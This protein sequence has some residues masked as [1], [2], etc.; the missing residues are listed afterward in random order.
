[1]NMKRGLTFCVVGMGMFL[2]ACG[3]GGGGGSESSNVTDVFFDDSVIGV[4][5]GTVAHV[6]FSFDSDHVFHDNKNVRVVVHLPPQ[7]QLRANTGEVQ[8][9]PT[10]ESI[11]AQVF[12]C[13][14]QA[15]T[16]LLFDLDGNDL[17]TAVNPGGDADA[18]L[19]F[20]VDGVS[21]VSGAIVSA[22]ASNEQPPFACGQQFL[23]DKDAAITVS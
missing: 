13:G 1:M 11:G 21:P 2:S 17:D 10:D 14:A 18:E 19:T 5:Q 7:I 22:T 4:G 8:A 15:E 3:G 9:V 23:A 6:K 16:F 20:T 12:S